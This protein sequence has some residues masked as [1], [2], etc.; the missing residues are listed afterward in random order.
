MT[1]VTQQLGRIFQEFNTL[2]EPLG[3]PMETV[4]ND[5]LSPCFIGDAIEGTEHPWKPSLNT[6]QTHDMFDRLGQALDEPIPSAIIDYYQF[7]WSQCLNATHPQGNL[8]LIFV[9]NEQDLERLRANLIGHA[10]NKQKLKQP[11]SYFFATTEPDGEKILSV[12]SHSGRVLLERPGQK[13]F[14]VISDSLGEFLKEISPLP[15]D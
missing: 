13:A 15:F 7:A 12:E 8:S 4:E 1:G 14:S 10:L 11:L 3:W 5:W 6:T 2:Q 9:W